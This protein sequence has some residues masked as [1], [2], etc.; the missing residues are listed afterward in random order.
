MKIIAV[1]TLLTGIAIHPLANA[2][3]PTTQPTIG[4]QSTSNDTSAVEE[5]VREMA[6]RKTEIEVLRKAL[7]E[8]RST[9]FLSEKADC[10]L[11][12]VNALMEE[13]KV[14]EV[15]GYYGGHLFIRSLNNGL[16]L[17]P[18][19]R[20]HVDGVAYAPAFDQP[21]Q[22]THSIFLRRARLEMNAGLFQEK[23]DAHLSGEFA[24][25]G[26]PIIAD[27]WVRWNAHPLIHLKVGRYNAPFSMENLVSDLWTDFIERSALVRNF[28]PTSKSVGAQVSG[29]IGDQFLTYRVGVF[30][31]DKG[32]IRNLDNAFD[33]I[34][35]FTIQPL[36]SQDSVLRKLRLGASFSGSQR[37][38]TNHPS[39][40]GDHKPGGWLNTSTGYSFLTSIYPAS[41]GK[42]TKIGLVPEG[43]GLSIGGDIDLPLDRFFVRAEYIHK[44]SDINENILHAGVALRSGGK[45]TSDGAY[46]TIGYWAVG[47]RGDIPRS[48]SVSSPKAI[49]LTLNKE[50]QKIASDALKLQVALRGEILHS[51]YEAGKDSGTHGFGP[52][53]LDGDYTMLVS[54]VGAN[55]WWTRHL[56]FSVNYTLNW[57]D[58]DSNFNLPEPG[59]NLVNEFA[60]RTALQF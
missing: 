24:K 43:L 57:V 39:L 15:A 50:D 36:T 45:M 37:S 58:K 7:E 40:G 6:E 2:E 14:P 46:L 34:G 33:V 31:G 10:D 41:D 22:P 9:R 8:E 32:E 26:G 19:M 38:G 18:R 49:P 11:D 16:R 17:S 54:T 25:A 20:L 1:F 4:S 30:N 27:A 13:S 55:L 28:A 3:E 53:R 52:G 21:G 56:R 44:E 29:V 35:R 5:L 48:G 47:R 42:D 60:F 51:A 23:V 12:C 59:Q